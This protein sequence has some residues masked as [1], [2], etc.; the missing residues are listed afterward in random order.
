M[1][2]TEATSAPTPGGRILIS[3]SSAAGKKP[4]MGID[5]ST[6]IK[7]LR[8]TSAFLLTA[9]VI[10]IK[11]AISSESRYAATIL[12]NVYEVLTNSS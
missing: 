9:I 10:P 11:I 6:S 4:S 5:W 8:I 12:A 1:R 2:K 7:G 3:I